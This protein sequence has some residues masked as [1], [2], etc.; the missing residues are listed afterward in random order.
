GSSTRSGPR[1]RGAPRH[2]PGTRPRR[3][4]SFHRLAHPLAGLV[5]R[6]LAALDVAAGGHRRRVDA[7]VVDHLAHALGLAR[8]GERRHAVAARRDGARE[9][10]HAV[11]DRDVDVGLAEPRAV[12]EPALDRVVQLLVGARDALGLARRHHL[13]LV[14]H[15]AHALDLARLGLGL[16]PGLL[17]VDG[18]EQR[19]DRVARVDVDV[20]GRRALVGDQTHLGRRGDP[21]V[22]GGGAGVGGLVVALLAPGLGVA[23]LF[24]A[25]DAVLDAPNAVDRAHVLERAAGDAQRARF[26]AEQDAAV[27]D[28]LDLDAALAQRGVGL[29]RLV[30]A[31]AQR[32]VAHGGGLPGGLRGIDLQQVAHLAHAFG[33]LRDLLGARLLLRRAHCTVERHA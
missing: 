1:R 10:R 11:L 30:H 25:L 16:A 15:L 22:A 26:A 24:G 6:A 21:R 8:E 4:R 32:L 29:E 13:Q 18:A 3:G 27:L 7:Q 2:R 19:H 5:A 20:E 14:A 9:A 17:R 31:L 12:L 28:R 23:E 33:R